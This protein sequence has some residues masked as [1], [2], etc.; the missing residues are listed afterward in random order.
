MAYKR[1]CDRCNYEIPNNN[2]V[3]IEF[4]EGNIYKYGDYHVDCFNYEFNCDIRKIKNGGYNN[5]R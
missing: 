3:K 2:F 5:D 1:I 4:K